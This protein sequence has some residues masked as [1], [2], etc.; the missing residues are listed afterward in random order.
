MSPYAKA[1]LS[2]LRLIAFGS[3]ILSLS[4]YS[5]DYFLYLKHQPMSGWGL[6]ALKGAPLLAGLILGWNARALAEHFTRDLD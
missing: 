1:V 3:I 2:V 4:L 5:T 6:L